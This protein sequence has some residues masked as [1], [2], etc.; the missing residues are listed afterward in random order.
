MGLWVDGGGACSL[1][2]VCSGFVRVDACEG[3]R[4]HNRNL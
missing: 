3:L 1:L 2:P 4:V